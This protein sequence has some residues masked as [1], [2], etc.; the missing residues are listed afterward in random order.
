MATDKEY[1]EQLSEISQRVERLRVHYQAY[2][3]GE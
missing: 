1:E 3:L 2:F